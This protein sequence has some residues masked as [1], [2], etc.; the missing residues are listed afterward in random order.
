MTTLTEFV[1]GMKFDIEKFE[2]MW[3]KNNTINPDNF[4]LEL[5]VGDWYEQF[6]TSEE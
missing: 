5:P 3:I 1:E 4:P 6:L 2:V